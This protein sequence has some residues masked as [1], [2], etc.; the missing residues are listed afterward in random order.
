MLPYIPGLQAGDIR[1]HLIKTLSLGR[2]RVA[3]LSEPLFRDRYSGADEYFFN[4]RWWKMVGVSNDVVHIASS[5]TIVP[6]MSWLTERAVVCSTMGPLAFFASFWIVA[7]MNEI[8]HCS[9]RAVERFLW[10]RRSTA[11]FVG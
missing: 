1:Q 7:E 10:K 3:F 6:E 9:L 4:E 11:F 5:A 8:H 2:I